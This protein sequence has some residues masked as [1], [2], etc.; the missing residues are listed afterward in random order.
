MLGRK[1]VERLPPFNPR[2]IAVCRDDICYANLG[3]DTEILPN[4]LIQD[5]EKG[6]FCR[7]EEHLI[8]LI[9]KQATRTCG[10][11]WPLHED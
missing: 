4:R 3:E 8:P 11:P 9:W 10:P 2:H 7:A 1:F 6:A 5:S